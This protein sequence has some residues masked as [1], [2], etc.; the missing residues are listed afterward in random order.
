MFFIDQVFTH[1]ITDSCT[2]VTQARKAVTL[3][4]WLQL[5]YRLKWHSWLVVLQWPVC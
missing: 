4:L 2:Y 5:L 1:C 3:L